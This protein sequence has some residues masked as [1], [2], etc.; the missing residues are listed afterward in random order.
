MIAESTGLASRLVGV[1]RHAV[2]RADR[3]PRRAAR[4]A[5]GAVTPAS[6]T[7]AAREN[8]GGIGWA[9][10]CHA[11]SATSVPTKF[12]TMCCRNAFAVNSNVTSTSGRAAA[13]RSARP[14]ADAFG[15]VPGNPPLETTRS[16]ARRARRPQRPSSQRNRVARAATRRV[17]CCSAGRVGLL[18][19]RVTITA[20]HGR[21]ARVEIGRHFLRPNEPRHRAADSS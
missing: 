11:R 6:R 3:P 17:A 15:D 14:S 4:P 2:V 19:D 9:A 8:R 5:G 13:P 10:A 7:V 21:A 16:R 18:Q 1:P 12:R 20:A